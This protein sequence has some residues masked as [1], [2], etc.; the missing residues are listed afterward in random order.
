[1]PYW[2]PVRL[3]AQ[4]RSESSPGYH[5][6]CT[7]ASSKLSAQVWFQEFQNIPATLAIYAVFLCKRQSNR[8]L[9]APK[10]NK[11]E[12]GIQLVLGRRV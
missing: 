8:Q 11:E 6:M 12:K 7:N 10:V 4:R 3:Y 5:F 1:M 2:F 9:A